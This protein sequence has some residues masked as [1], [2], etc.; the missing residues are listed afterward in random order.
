MAKL[1]ASELITNSLEHAGLRRGDVIE[2]RTEVTDGH[3]R[4]SVCDPGPGPGRRTQPGLG[5]KVVERA[6]ARWGVERGDEVSCVWFEI[7]LAGEPLGARGD[8]QRG[9][10]P[11]HGLAR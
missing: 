10:R 7:D 8:L 4:V 11:A 5:L 3:L 1:A 9:D 6:S 2:L